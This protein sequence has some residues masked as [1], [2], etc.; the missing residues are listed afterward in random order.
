MIITEASSKSYVGD[1]ANTIFPTTFTFAVNSDVRVYVG[2]VLKVEGPDYA[3][4]GAGTEGGGT[5][6]FVAAPAAAAAVYIER[7][8]PVLQETD[9]RPEGRYEADDIEELFD[10][11][12]RMIQELVRRVA[13]L[14]ALGSLV[15]VANVAN[16][17]RYAG[18]F[19]TDAGSVEATFPFDIVVVNGKNALDAIWRVFLTANEAQRFDTPPAVQWKPGAT[20]DAITISGISGLQPGTQYT[21][22]G[23]VLF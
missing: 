10:S 9:L 18:N 17:T 15:N 1:G 11:R 7:D 21:L 8:T 20:P 13:A 5:V 12:T 3:L 4:V 6:T 23:L 16:G 19:N 14:E 2:G 22:K